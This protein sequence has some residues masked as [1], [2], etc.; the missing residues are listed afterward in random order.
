MLQNSPDARTST[1]AV[2][3]AMDA[4][5]PP[6]TCCVARF[7]ELRQ[8]LK[9][10]G[11]LALETL[12]IEGD[13][14]AVLVPPNR[15]GRMGNVWFIPSARAVQR[16]LEKLRFRDVRIVD[17]CSTTTEE[18]RSTDWMTFQSLADFL[19]PQDSSKTV[20]GHPAPLRAMLVAEA[21]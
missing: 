5:S 15:Y 19:D 1:T 4:I 12:V 8:L 18:Q 9:P 16:W 3:T 10:G 14:N 17:V 21:P 6:P 13:E 2:L 11:Q 7:L 20:E